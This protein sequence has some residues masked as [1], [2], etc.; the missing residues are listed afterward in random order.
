MSVCQA[1][2]A[3]GSGVGP[4]LIGSLSDGLDATIGIAIA[5]GVSIGFLGA[6][7]FFLAAR[8]ARSASQPLLAA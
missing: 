4:F 1:L 6:L 2:A 7:H 8:A 5:C 3:L